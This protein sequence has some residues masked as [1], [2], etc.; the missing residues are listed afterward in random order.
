MSPKESVEPIGSK[1]ENE[2]HNA[3]DSGSGAKADLCGVTC[4]K[5]GFI[6]EGERVA[7]ICDGGEKFA[8]FRI[9]PGD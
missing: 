2:S 8:A 5:F 4:A 7:R 9:N 1:D 6:R 3:G